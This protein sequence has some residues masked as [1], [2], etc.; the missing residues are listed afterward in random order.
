MY[1][2]IKYKTANLKEEDLYQISFLHAFLYYVSVIEWVEWSKLLLLS[3]SKKKIGN[4]SA[5]L[6]I[7]WW[8]F[9]PICVL[10]GL[11]ELNGEILCIYVLNGMDYGSFNVCMHALN[12]HLESAVTLKSLDINTIH[13]S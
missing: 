2:K 6:C 8:K 1:P 9:L 12:M 11:N 4:F 3:G 5:Y 13:H 7:E 10:N